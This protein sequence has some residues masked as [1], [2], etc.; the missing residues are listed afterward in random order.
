MF[1]TTAAQADLPFV[2]CADAI[3][4]LENVDGR[5]HVSHKKDPFRRLQAH[6]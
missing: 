4:F 5:R 3:R 1:A 2:L 6:D